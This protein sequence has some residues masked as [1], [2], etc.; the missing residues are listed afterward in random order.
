MVTIPFFIFFSFMVSHFFSH[1][2]DE[3]KKDLATYFIYPM[4]GLFA[5]FMTFGRICIRWYK[6]KTSRF[7]LSN[8]R[9][10]FTDKKGQF[11]DKSFKLD[12]I[13]ISYREDLYGSGY[14]I[15]GKP[16][17]LFQG[18]G[19]NFFENQDVMYNVLHVK[20]VFDLINDS[21]NKVF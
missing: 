19:V 6:T 9:L 7:Y 2:L 1:S 4:A 10:I 20:K 21:K 11:I 13:E 15:V 8:Q 12:G 18:R 3:S 17:P 16:E 5:L 14:I